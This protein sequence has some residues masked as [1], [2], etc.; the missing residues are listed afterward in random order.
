MAH[1][2]DTGIIG[3]SVF[4]KFTSLI[5]PLAAR[6]AQH[7]KYSDTLRELESLSKREL[8]DLGLSKHTLR[9]VAHEAA[10]GSA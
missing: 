2:S 10:F 3:S 9:A 6:Y 5:K 8:N 4:S 7:K 1:T